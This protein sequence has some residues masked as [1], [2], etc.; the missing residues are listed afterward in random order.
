MSYLGRYSATG[1]IDLAV[2]ERAL[3]SLPLRDCSQ[4]VTYHQGAPSCR[5][6]DSGAIMA[7]HWD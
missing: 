4:S 2:A 1:L 3:L 7:F 6:L 5:H